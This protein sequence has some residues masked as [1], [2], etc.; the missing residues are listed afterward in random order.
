MQSLV[1]QLGLPAMSSQSSHLC[2]LSP[3]LVLGV[4]SVPPCFLHGFWGPNMNVHACYKHFTNRINLP[5][6]VS[7]SM[8]LASGW[9]L[10]RPCEKHKTRETFLQYPKQLQTLELLGATYPHELKRMPLCPSRSDELLQG[11]F[12]PSLFL[13]WGKSEGAFGSWDI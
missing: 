11:R 9:A 5:A 7:F 12:I 3:V 10:I 4:H 8:I 6:P 2:G 1:I 13:I